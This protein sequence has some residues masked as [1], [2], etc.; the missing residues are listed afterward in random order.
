MMNKKLKYMIA[1]TIVVG[2]IS[3]IT[4]QSSEFLDINNVKAKV[5][6]NNYLFNDPSSSSA[7]YE[8]PI[9]SGKNT[10]YSLN[11]MLLG[12]DVN[13]QLKG[14]LPKF[15]NSSDL[16]AGPIMNPSEYATSAQ[17]WDRVWKIDCSTIQ[18]FKNWHQAGIDDAVNG[19]TTQATNFPGYVIPSSI[20]D[21]PAHGD[22]SKGQN[23]HIAPFFDKDQDGFYDPTSGDYPL[24]KGD[25]AIFFVYNDER[26]TLLAPKVGTEVRVM[27]YA[28]GN[29]LDSALENT[30]FVNYEII[31][32]SSYTLSDVHVALD[33]D[34]DIGGP[35]DDYV[36]S[37]VERASFYAFNGDGFDADENGIL[38]YG[39]NL[40][41]QS[42]V[43]L[44]G[45]WL[46]SDGTDSPYT[47]NMQDAI[48]SNGYVYDYCNLGF[49]DGI[50]DNERSSLDN[51][52]NYGVTGVQG[53]PNTALDYYN[54]SRGLWKDGSP[55][56][57]G[58]NGHTSGGGIVPAKYAY[59]GV[60]DPWTWGTQGVATNPLNWS[61]INEGNV[62]GDRKGI[63]SMGPFTMQPGAVNR[64]DIALVSAIDY[65]GG[66]NQAPLSIMNERIDSVR[67]YFCNGLISNCASGVFSTSIASE[68]SNEKSMVIA[69]NPFINNFSLSYKS[70]TNSATLSIYNLVGEKIMSQNITQEKTNIDL[71][72]QPNGIYLI[73]IIDGVNMVTKKII[74]Q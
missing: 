65:A 48:D 66:G 26:K 21:W 70:E 38:G 69:P 59:T 40:A 42:V 35:M 64:I 51:F 46:D 6:A 71:S 5:N 12:Q 4:A 7:G 19:T 18:T 67:S 17:V 57:Y 23:W 33:V 62:P 54:Y 37:D 44:N 52:I 60:S 10:I 49:G 28:F 27:V 20:L 47:I 25:Q 56:V 63:G 16:H 68:T 36:G 61:E 34:F 50:V 22:I 15:V 32:R 3:Q 43:V 74:K 30:I 72:N 13:G 45:P 9:N 53:A 31:N 39:N 2:S 11:L 24:I 55:M 41:A 1:I 58:G 8:Y 14:N 73:T 29:T